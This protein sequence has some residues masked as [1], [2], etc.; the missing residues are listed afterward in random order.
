MVI[1][2]K[3]G[4]TKRNIQRL[5]HTLFASKKTHGIDT[6]KYCG[7]ISLEKSALEIQKELR[8]EWE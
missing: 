8:D 5:L 4:E 7:T 6:H 1:V 2:L 3:R